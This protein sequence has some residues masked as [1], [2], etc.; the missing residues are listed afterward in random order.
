MKESYVSMKLLLGKTKYDE[1]KWKLCGDL[2]GMALLL[3]MPLG[4][5]NYCCFLYE[6]DSWDKNNHYVNKPW[7]KRPSLA[8]RKENVVNPPLVLPEKIYLPL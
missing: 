2:K 7:P 6:W 5:T 1:L 8:P 4:Y 3:R